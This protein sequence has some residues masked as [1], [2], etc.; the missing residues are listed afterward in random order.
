MYTIIRRLWSIINFSITYTHVFPH[1]AQHFSPNKPALLVFSTPLAGTSRFDFHLDYA[2]LLKY[3]GGI[4]ALCWRSWVERLADIWYHLEV[5]DTA[6]TIGLISFTV[7]VPLLNVVMN[8]I[9]R[10]AL[11]KGPNCNFQRAS[12]TDM[13]FKLE[14][15]IN[16][17]IQ[18]FLQLLSASTDTGLEKFK[19]QH[20]QW[21]DFQNISSF[22]FITLNLC[23]QIMHPDNYPIYLS[24]NSVVKFLGIEMPIHL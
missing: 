14:T 20:G 2:L 13:T 12:S 22:C 19:L 8:D 21:A 6:T 9:H 24:Y 16:T 23:L 17:L 3:F 18:H 7:R 1:L 11:H 15:D 10:A 4:C 5:G